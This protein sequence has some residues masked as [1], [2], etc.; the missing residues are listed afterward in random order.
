MSRAKNWTNIEII[1]CQAIFV[2]YLGFLF[3]NIL[4]ETKPT[5]L[6]SLIGGIMGTSQQDTFY[7]LFYYSGTH[8]TEDYECDILRDWKCI[9][10]WQ[11]SPRW[12][13]PIHN[14]T[15]RSFNWLSINYI[16]TIM[17]LKPDC[18]Q[19]KHIVIIIIKPF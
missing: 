17:I 4:P 18:I 11:S 10:K 3:W 7:I 2:T 6:I 5:P 13:F 12:Q 8:K 15:H 16:S 9:F 1:S 19:W 14:G